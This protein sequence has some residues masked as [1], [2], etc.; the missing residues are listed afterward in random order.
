M[1][2]PERITDE[3]LSAP[4]PLPKPLT[5]QEQADEYQREAIAS[6]QSEEAFEANRK[7]YSK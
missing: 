2:A 6:A 5:E 3:W 1:N 4:W 7:E